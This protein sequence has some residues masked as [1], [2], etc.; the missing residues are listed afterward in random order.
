MEDALDVENVV[1]NHI[2][3]QGFL[4]RRLDEIAHFLLFLL[5]LFLFHSYNVTADI[6]DVSS[7]EAVATTN[8]NDDGDGKDGG[9]IVDDSV[10]NYFQNL[11]IWIPHQYRHSTDHGNKANH[12]RLSSSSL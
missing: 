10:S 1:F 8:N 2:T 9:D 4:F 6:I 3:Q 5:F 12:D 7:L 11:G